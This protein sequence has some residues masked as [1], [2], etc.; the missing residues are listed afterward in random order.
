MLS[1]EEDNAIGAVRAILGEHFTNFGIVVISE[2][3]G[4]MHYE[5]NHFL[6][7]KALFKEAYDEM[8][9]GDTLSDFIEWEEAEIDDEEDED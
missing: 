1:E 6:I 8:N 2:D 7:G 5:Y 3:V 4:D 9:E